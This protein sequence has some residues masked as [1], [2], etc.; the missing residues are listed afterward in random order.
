MFKRIRELL[1][2]GNPIAKGFSFASG[3]TNQK[4]FENRERNTAMLLKCKTILQ[5]GGI[6]SEALETYPTFAIGPGWTFQGENPR[7]VDEVTQFYESFDSHGAFSAAILDGEAYGD[8][9]Q[10]IVHTRGG[11][12]HSIVPRPSYTFKVIQGNTDLAPTGYRQTLSTFMGIEKTE[13]FEPDKILQFTPR[14]ITGYPYGQSLILRAYDDIMRDT[15]TA[16][17]TAAA[18]ERHGFPKY[19]VRVGREGETVQEEDMGAVSKTFKDINAK[20]EFI[21]PF[22]VLMANID[23]GG[24][25]NVSQYNDITLTRMCAALGVPEELLGLRRGTTDATAV[26]RIQVFYKKVENRQKQLARAHNLRV[27]DKITQEPGAVKLVFNDVSPQD[28]AA[29]AEWIVKMMEATPLDPFAV[30]PLDWIQ[31]RLGIEVDNS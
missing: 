1:A 17:S 29:K 25:P 30:L 13:T 27:I 28:E 3:G 14:P 7:Q 8:A 20:N 31:E 24:L 23:E 22:D 6:I 21:T 12:I 26:S 18:I 16:E 9:F 10:E 11:E 15:K 4:Y 5:Q 2:K 19:H